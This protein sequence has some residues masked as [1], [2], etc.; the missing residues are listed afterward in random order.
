M[1][2]SL[3]FS[4]PGIP[5]SND[6]AWDEF[7]DREEVNEENEMEPHPLMKE[8]IIQL[9]KKYPCICTLPDE[10]IDEGLWAD[11]PIENNIIGDVLIL[12]IVFSKVE[13]ALP[14]IVE[15]AKKVGVVF[16]DPQTEEIF[17][18]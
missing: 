11:G 7:D 18:S 4:I 5:E 17:R 13:E 10:K 6:E 12:A 9:T 2:Y 1:S 15:T 8:L 14:F 3:M 16:Y